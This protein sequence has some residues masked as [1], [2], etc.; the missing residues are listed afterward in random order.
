MKKLVT[1]RTVQYVVQVVKSVQ[2]ELSLRGE[3]SRGSDVAGRSAFGYP[4][5]RFI[6]L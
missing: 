4:A 5:T 6:T 2:V 1:I 3:L